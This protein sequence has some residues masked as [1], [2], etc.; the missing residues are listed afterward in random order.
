MTCC[1]FTADRL[2]PLTRVN[3]TAPVC[4]L[5]SQLP[6]RVGGRKRERYRVKERREREIAREGREREIKSEREI[7]PV[8]LSRC[9]RAGGEMEER[10]RR[11]GG[12]MKESWRRDEGELEE[13]WRR[14]GGELERSEERRVGTECRSLWSPSH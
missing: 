13:S 10:W 1:D 3:V 4:H 8:L 11:D 12:E 2:R 9:G 14:A 7:P 5:T 6:A